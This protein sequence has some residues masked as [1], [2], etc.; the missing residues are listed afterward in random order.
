MEEE[1]VWGG[2]GGMGPLMVDKDG[3]GNLY[4]IGEEDKIRAA[5]NLVGGVPEFI[6]MIRDC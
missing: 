2:I 4:C 3:R 5:I 1:Y 6:H